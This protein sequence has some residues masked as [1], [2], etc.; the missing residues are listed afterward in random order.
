MTICPADWLAQDPDPQTRQTLTDLLARAET[1]DTE[2]QAELAQAFS[3]PL[4]FGTA[5][6][7]AALG[8]GPARLNQVV[9]MQAA[10]GF[11]DWLLGHGAHPGDAVLIGYDARHKSAD[12]AT[13]TAEVMAGAGLRPIMTD[14]P[15]PTPVLAFGVVHLGCAAGVQVTAS[16][17]P[18]T[19]N[20][21]KVYLGD[22]CQIVPP[23]DAE[24]AALIAARAALPLSAIALSKQYE[25]IGDSLITA[26]VHR[27]A[28]QFA[29]ATAN[30]EG[31]SEVVWAYTAMHGV[32]TALIDEVVA[33]THLPAPVTVAEQARPDP[34]FPTVEFPNP[35][36]PGAM[37]MVIKLAQQ[38]GADLA[39]ATDPDADRCALAAPIDGAWRRLSGD[40]VGALLADDALRRQVPGV[41]AASIVSSTML[42]DMAAAAGRRFVTTLTGFKWIG[43]VPHLGF[44]Y[45]EA[46]GYCCDPE[47]VRDKDGI[48]ATAALLRLAGQLKADGQTIADALESIDQ[49]FGVHATS[50]HSLRVPQISLIADMMA[51]LRSDPPTQLGGV[52]VAVT[53]LAVGGALPAT[54]GL[55][56]A[57]EKVR[58]VVR[59]SGTEPKLKCYLQA[60]QPAGAP[61]LA[62]SRAAAADM[63]WQLWCDMARALGV[64]PE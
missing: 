30:L 8:P 15:V 28:D 53:D 21:Y 5:G 32:G 33:A 52:A 36:E 7:R 45:E 56:F 27:I 20:G 9:V 18:A 4:T 31:P 1:G 46:I 63:V 14:R 2:A 38:V 16:H 35:E 10:A 57:G 12:F 47:A 49:R 44:G 22:G 26:Y 58:V 55:L 19:D 11:A 24:I 60:R 41:L 3:G 34:D 62:A 17:N 37:D 48:S 29:P 59:P 51:K 23:A 25:T 42:A 50:Q 40:E 61:D 54:D 6:L 43:R 13:A 64:Q 39:I